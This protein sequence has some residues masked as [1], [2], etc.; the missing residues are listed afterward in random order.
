MKKNKQ[1]DNKPVKK[2]KGWF[3][4]LKQIMRIRYKRPVYVYLGKEFDYGTLILSNHEGTDAPMA[5]EIYS[6]KP[7]R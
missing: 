6:R 7:I 2:R 1:I 3:K 4:L 5:L